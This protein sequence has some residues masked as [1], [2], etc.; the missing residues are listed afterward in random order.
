M[1]IALDATPLIEPAGGLPRYVTELALALAELAPGDEIHLLSDQPDLY[2]DPRLTATRNV[3]LEPPAA[4][5]RSKWWSFGLPKEL[6]SRRIDIFHG[7]NFEIPYLPLTPA[8]MTVHDLSPWKPPPLRP[9]GCERVRTRA[10]QLIRRARKVITPTE[11]IREEVIREFRL[12]PAQVVAIPHA[13]SEALAPAAERAAA[14]RADLRLPQRYLLAIG[15]GNARKNISLLVNAWHMLLERESDLGLVVVGRGAETAAAD[16]DARL[17]V[18]EEANDEQ[19]AA[20]LS[21]AQAFVYPSLYEGFGLP[22]VE[23]MRARVP[24]L[25]SADQAVVEVAAGAA[26][27]FEPHSETEL[28]EAL[29]R[30]LTDRGEAERLIR[31]GERRAAEL[32]WSATAKKTRATYEQAIGRK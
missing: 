9:P 6:R 19:T 27:H 12:L 15:A 26:L 24:V 20:A 8:V 23:A 10:P 21:G 30:V 14:I 4:W 2:V 31:L 5:G 1:R 32:S 11:A 28:V 3:R 13:P 29:R 17:V 16:G 7:T 18:I 22:V 25:A